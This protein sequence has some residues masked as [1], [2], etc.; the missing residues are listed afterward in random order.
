MDQEER[1]ELLRSAK[2][3]ADVLPTVKISTRGAVGNNCYRSGYILPYIR[4]ILLNLTKAI[5]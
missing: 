2:A 5:L 1:P 4:S 3:E